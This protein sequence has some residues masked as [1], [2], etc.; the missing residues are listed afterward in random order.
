MIPL[1]SVRASPK[2]FPMKF[3]VSLRILLMVPVRE[4]RMESVRVSPKR[5]SLAV[6]AW[7][8]LVGAQ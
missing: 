7:G 4:P 1:T 6:Y 8:L 3:V 5:F 2:M